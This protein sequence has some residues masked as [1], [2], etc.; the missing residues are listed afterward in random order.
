MAVELAPKNPNFPS[1][2][3]AAHYRA[4]DWK[5]AI[6]A[7]EQSRAMREGGDAHEW[8]F[9]AMAHWQLGE[10][11]KARE[12]YDRAAKWME[13]HPP[14]S[15]ELRRFRAEAADVLSAKPKK[16]D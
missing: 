2:L 12:W 6:A 11:V 8:F 13:K 1:T 3:G 7:L 4:R 5:A 14:G 15:D 9:L 16:D 10:K